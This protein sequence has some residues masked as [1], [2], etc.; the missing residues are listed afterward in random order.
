MRHRIAISLLC[1]L[2]AAGCSRPPASTADLQPWIAVTGHYSLVSAPA[3]PQPP[4]PTPDSDKCETCGGKGWLGDV[5]QTRLT[6]TDCNG[7][8]RKVKSVLIVPSAPAAAAL[9]CKD[10]RCTTRTIV[11]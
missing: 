1:L 2:A 8:G 9:N 10:G 4:A 11:R 5:S 6:C 3:A 7:T